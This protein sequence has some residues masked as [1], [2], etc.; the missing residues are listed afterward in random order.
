MSRWRRLIEPL[1][2]VKLTL[3]N[4][5][6]LMMLVFIG[7]LAQV[8]MGTFAAQRHYFNRFWVTFPF[9]GL[10]VPLFPGGL[11]VGALW[12]VNLVA[13]FIVRFRP[14]KQD[15]GLYLSH[16]GLIV[17]L[18]GQ[19]FAQTLAKESQMP[20][21]VGQSRNY[22]ETTREMEFAMTHPVDA[23][24]DE[25]T[26]IRESV[27]ARQGTISPPAL[28]FSV[29]IR[30]FMRNARLE[31]GATHRLE[32]ITQGIGLQVGAQE[33]PPVSSDEEANN[34]TVVAEIIAEGKSLGVWLVSAGLGMPQSVTVRGRDYQ[35]AMRP[36]RTYLPFTLTLKKFTHDIYPGTDIPKNFASLLHLSHLERQE[37]RDV[38]IYMNHPLRY[39]GR[40]FYQASFGEG[41]QLSVLQVVENPFSGLPYVSCAMVVLGLAIHFLVRMRNSRK[42][43]AI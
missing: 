14:R 36:R 34:T 22:S 42:R 35:L 21:P 30:R 29:V 9:G 18:I 37:N 23:E 24:L 7:T 20:I 43:T 2:S 15:V 1:A 6:L 25:V 19:F 33:L 11:T 8:N 5:G 12:I 40:T 16:L 41:D 26:V 27:L 38:L 32:G 31:N 13:A 28:P 10:P 17:L 3:V 4:L 39:A